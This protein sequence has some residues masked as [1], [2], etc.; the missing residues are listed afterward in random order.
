[1][2]CPMKSNLF[3]FLLVVTVTAVSSI[4]LGAQKGPVPGS[5]VY[6]WKNVQIVGGGFVDGIVFHPREKGVCYARTDM[7][8]AYRRN[9]ET[10]R[11]E[12]L[13]DWVSYDDLNLMGVESIALD[14]SDP[15]RVYLACGTYTNPSTPNG[16]ILRSDD[17]GESF[18]RTD[19]PFKMGGNEDGRGNGERMAV[20][21]NN[22]NI[23]YLGTRLA[24][25]WKTTDRSQSWQQVTSFPD[26]TEVPPPGLQGRDSLIWQWRNRGSGI[27]FVI[28]DGRS[29]SP[30][31][32]S[33]DIYAGVSLMGRRNFFMSRDA[34]A[35]WNAV[36]GQPEDL[37]PTHAVLASDGTMY[38]TYGDRPGPS[39]MTD[40]AVWKYDTGDGSWTEITPDKPGPGREFGYAAVSVE[41]GNPEHLIVSS[42]HRYGIEAGDDIFRSTDGG[43][44]WRQIFGGGGTFND[45]LAPYVAFTGIHWLFDIEIDPFDPD[46][47]IFT[48]GYGGHE[49]F[50][51]TD[52]DRGKAT[53]WRVM[54]SGIDE[55]VPLELLSPPEGAWVISAVGDYG[56]F[57]HRNLDRPQPEGNFSSPRFGN[58]TGVA[59]AS[60]KPGIIVRAGYPTGDNPGQ[61]VG[62]SMDGG[63][64]WQP[65]DSI[66]DPSCRG[67]HV[68]V[69]ADGEIW[70]WS[71]EA[72][73][74]GFGPDAAGRVFPVYYTSDRGTTWNECRGIPGG[75]RVIADPVV[76]ARFYAM[77]LFGGT[78]YISD[79][80]GANFTGTPL[81]LPGGIPGSP[82]GR[83]DNR[84]GQDRIY[85]APGASG[86]LWIAAFDGLFHSKESGRSFS[87]N[88]SVEQIHAFGFG[89]AAPESS[90]PAL[91]LVGTISGIRGIFRSDDTGAS[92]T[93]INDDRHQWGLILHV[94]GDPKKYGRVYVGTHGRGLIYGDPL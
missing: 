29:G 24:G 81:L 44:S 25:L 64:S 71:P 9:P 88:P 26:V 39:N 78:L 70:I 46:H 16:A 51:L 87:R 90:C 42:Y 84:G 67:G 20:D 14:P 38:I 22:G 58:T 85:A 59:C 40:G 93:R 48:T 76:S 80:R 36:P 15:D 89:K 91:Y 8:G 12:P 63:K 54:S 83:G 31:R 28:F 41:S 79:D 27:I 61:P 1:M 66:P 13:L 68:A 33:T 34:G 60:L 45:S 55:T 57:V 18:H 47:A 17:R 21:P 86:D 74:R 49:T 43:V 82:S 7:G 2:P 52:A 4:E 19:V 92:W 72:V 11:W 37:R 94:T 65:A 10:L 62:F 53:E 69:S 75:T 32:G 50:H 3:Q 6:I 77:D 35:T 30:G 5:E 56:G 73:R 23:L